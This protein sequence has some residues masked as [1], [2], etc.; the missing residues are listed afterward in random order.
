M[1]LNKTIASKYEKHEK[2]AIPLIKLDRFKKE[3][4]NE[5]SY[6][7]T[8]VANQAVFAWD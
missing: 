6:S 1:I 7:S 4:S 2:L 5:A 3:C 8:N